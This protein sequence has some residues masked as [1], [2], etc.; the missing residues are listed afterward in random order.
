MKEFEVTWQIDITAATPE[1]AARVALRMLRDPKSVATV[2][3]VQR[4]VPAK[5]GL[6][7]QPRGDSVRVDVKD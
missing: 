1:Q 2:F 5:N 4:M 7:M 3:D 6:G